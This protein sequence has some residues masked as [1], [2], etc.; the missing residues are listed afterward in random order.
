MADEENVAAR[1][2]VTADLAVHLQDQRTGGVDGVQRPPPRLAMDGLGDA[3]GGE[4]HWAVRLDRVKLVDKDRAHGG[5]AFDHMGVVNNLVAHINRRAVQ[6]EG[7]LDGAD[8]ALHAGA[9]S[10]RG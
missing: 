10:A 2:G 7:L 4:N 9:K 3:V 6:G 5:K 1:C 8:G